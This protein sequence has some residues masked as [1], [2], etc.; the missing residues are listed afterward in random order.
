[1]GSSRRSAR[2]L[3]AVV[4]SMV[5]GACGGVGPRGSSPGSSASHTLPN[6][7]TIVA[8]YSASSLGLKAP[9][10]LAIGPNGYIYVTDFAGQNVTVVSAAGKVLRR[11]GKPGRGPGDFSF[12]L[13]PDGNQHAHISVSPDG[14]VYVSDGGNLRV[15]VF[16]P[17]GDF[18]RQYGSENNYKFQ[19]PGYLAVD[20]TNDLYVGD[21]VPNTI[22]KFTPS[23]I[24]LWRVG[25]TGETDP[26]L[27]CFRPESVHIA[28]VDPHGRV[29]VAVDNGPGAEPGPGR[30]IYLDGN[31]HKVDAFGQNGDF[32]DG[33]CDVTVDAAGDTFVHS[34]TDPR[35]VEV[36]D[37]TH[38]LI[39]AWYRSPFVLSP[40]FGAGGEIFTLGDDQSILKL[41]V[42]IPVA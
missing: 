14:K 32:P 42:T 36:F 21:L 26:D 30:I 19:D 34:C 39:G 16:S 24:S 38:R 8:R 15:E 2:V 28:S 7:F 6:P 22:S 17:T 3:A 25:G 41:K 18:I 5:I 12:H 35:N 29:V 4:A 33:T 20:S 1:M 40:R 11:W 9:N 27:C 23:G 37:R 10:D 31:G 13:D